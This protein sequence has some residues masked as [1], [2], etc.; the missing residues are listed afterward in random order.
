MTFQKNNVYIY[1]ILYID[2]MI[3]LNR[4]FGRLGNNIIQLKHIIHIAIAYK[5]NV[6]I[7]VRKL[8]FFD[9]SVIERY[10][11]KY[12]NSEIVTDSSDFYYT[13][14]LPF[15]NDIFNQNIEERNKILQE[16]F[17]IHNIHKLPENDL[18]IHIRSGDVFSSRP[19]PNYVPPPLSYYT[20]QINKCNYGKIQW[21]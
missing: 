21:K 9:L 4:L 8:N 20:K 14:R 6:K 5:H 2:D 7:N 11:D 19:H 12:K 18:V 3:I 10:F 1:I 17:L 15:S 13:S 16:A